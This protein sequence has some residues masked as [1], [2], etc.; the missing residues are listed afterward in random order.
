M[1]RLS[2]R[3][4]R[5]VVPE[6][7]GPGEESVWDYPRPPR[8][9]AFHGEVRVEAR[10]KTLARSSRAVRVLETSHPPAYYI[11][12]DDV[13]MTRLVENDL[14]TG[15]EFKGRASYFDLCPEGENPSVRNVA[16]TYRNPQAG[17]EALRDTLCFYP[18][19]VDA[20]Y[21]NGERVTPQ[22]GDFYGGWVTSTIR[23]PFKGAPGTFGW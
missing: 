10:G 5:G 7:V 3:I 14:V 8:V 16:W 1:K 21:V 4:P 19:R 11:P 23:G 2:G 13:D 17:F 12:S 18:S 6:S 22:E 15:C 9:E 20:C